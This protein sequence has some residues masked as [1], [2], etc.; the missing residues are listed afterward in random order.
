M[1]LTSVVGKLLPLQLRWGRD[2]PE[3]PGELELF[4]STFVRICSLGTAGIDC[5]GAL[6]NQN[7]L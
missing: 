1:W 7:Y 2:P 5:F 3:E 6:D 4:S